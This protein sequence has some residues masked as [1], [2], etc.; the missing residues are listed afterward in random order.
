MA[1]KNTYSCLVDNRIAFFIRD[2]PRL[3]GRGGATCINQTFTASTVTNKAK[4]STGTGTQY[5]K[6]TVVRVLFSRIAVA[7][8][9]AP[10]FLM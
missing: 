7:S 4:Q 10:A 8:S 2:D 5:Y 3:N 6:Q 9:A 1:C